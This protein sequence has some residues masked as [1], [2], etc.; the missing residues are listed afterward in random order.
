MLFFIAGFDTV[1]SAM[2]FLIHELTLNPDVQHRLY[3]EIATVH[4]ELDGKVLDYITL[5]K[6]KYIDMVLSE[7]L[8]RWAPVPTIARAV[9]KAYDLKS[10][11]GTE[12]HLE[13][14]DG[15]W[16]PIFGFHLDEKY[17]PN[18]EKFDPERFNDQNKQNIKQEAYIPFGMG[19][20]KF[21]LHF[22]IVEDEHYRLISHLIHF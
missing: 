17:F 1:S 12:I 18:P 13:R 4:K 7:S 20:S 11:D 5:S 14:D 19:P 22:I 9:T 6:M 16:V 3:K 21:D 8:R 2:S 10:S 15:I